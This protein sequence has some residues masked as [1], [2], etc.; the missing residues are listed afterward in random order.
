MNRSTSRHALC[1]TA[2]LVCAGLG[3][4]EDRPAVVAGPLMAPVATEAPSGEPPPA[5]PSAEAPSVATS[6][7]PAVA[8]PPA[9]HPAYAAAGQAAPNRAERALGIAPA[10]QPEADAPPLRVDFRPTRRGTTGSSE[11]TMDADAPIPNSAGCAGGLRGLSG[12]FPWGGSEGGVWKGTGHPDPE[13]LRAVTDADMLALASDVSLDSVD[14]EHALVSVGR[15][16]LPG[17]LV[18]FRDSLEPS[19]PH[20]VREM[21][22]SG[23]IEHGGADALRLMWKAL[24]D[25]PSAHMRGMAIW[26]I[27]LYGP[28]EAIKAITTGLSDPT[29]SVQGMAILAV[30]AVKDRPAVAL[31]ILQAAAEADER[32]LWQEGLNVL[33]RMPYSDAGNRLREIAHRSKGEK[34]NSAVFY[35]RQWRNNFPD[36]CK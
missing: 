35:Y 1:V 8:S 2:L 7:A 19:Q 27:A 31:P 13:P 4:A 5:V 29:Y 30:W 32:L 6:P 18:A 26:A 15:R 9:D 36:L 23:L 16:K 21:A 24:T 33:A 3:C 20:P 22:L 10:P 28:D 17:A 14:R 25:D 34:R 11:P 12:E